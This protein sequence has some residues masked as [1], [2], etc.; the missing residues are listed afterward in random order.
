MFRFK[1]MFYETQSCQNFENSSCVN[2]DIDAFTYTSK[3]YSFMLSAVDEH[4]LDN[5][6]E[7]HCDTE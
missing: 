4:L 2:W 1:K 6:T 5:K 7:G 3:V